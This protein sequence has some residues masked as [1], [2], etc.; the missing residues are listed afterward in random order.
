MFKEDDLNERGPEHEGAM[1]GESATAIPMEGGDESTAS[2]A[3]EVVAA[4]TEISPDKILHGMTVFIVDD[5]PL[6]ANVA[7]RIVKGA[8]GKA[9][10]V[11]T[12]LE[13]LERI[14]EGAEGKIGI[15]T[16]FVMPGMDG[17]QLA[18]QVRQ[19]EQIR[20][21]PILLSSGG[22]YE[23]AELDNAL[24]DGTLDGILEKPFDHK[25][26][27]KAIQAVFRKRSSHE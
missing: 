17:I 6:V 12:G 26:L 27:V 11:S 4:T 10:T 2:R 16:D 20:D 5:D 21:I 3:N 8:G 22:G 19:I 13:C 1:T 24:A 7:G 23:Q 9:I 15:V 18:R 14:R 25:S